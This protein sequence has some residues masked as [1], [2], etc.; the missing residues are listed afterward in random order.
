M[1]PT[2][3]VL[4]P[5]LDYDC[6]QL[7]VD[8]GRKGNEEGIPTEILLGDDHSVRPD[9]HA[10]LARLSQIEGVRVLYTDKHLGRALNRNRLAGEARGEW[11]LF[12]DCDAQVPPAFS[13]RA[14]LEA[15]RQADVVCGGLRHPETNPCPEATLR[16]KYECE[17]DRRRPARFRNGH[18]WGQLSTFSLLIRRSVFLDIRFD[19]QCVHYGYE[20]TLFGAELHRR[21]IPVLHIDDPLLHM[22]L[23]PNPVFLAK[24]ETSLRTL[25]SLQDKLHG[26][27]R[28]LATVERLRRMHLTRPARL[29]WQFLRKPLRANLLGRRPS[30][31]LFSVYK[32]GYYL[33]LR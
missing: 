9:T 32:L 15:S 31:F 18:P 24:T 2:L 30:L 26:H 16:Y 8:I 21:G 11:L 13:L 22:G 19:E 23:E 5:V 3:S 6:E 33:C 20:D 7:V 29:A 28:L 27:S 4:I 10:M 12:V 1:S 17:A 25:H 14:Y